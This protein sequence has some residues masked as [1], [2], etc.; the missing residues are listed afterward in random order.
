MKIYKVVNCIDCKYLYTVYVADIHQYK[1]KC[2][3]TGKMVSHNKYIITD[4][5]F[6]SWC[7]LEDYKETDH[8][9]SA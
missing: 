1:Y 4:N 2:I 3:S 9:K 8:E 6:P 7:P 5:K